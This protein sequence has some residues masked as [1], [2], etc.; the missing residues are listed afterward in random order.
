MSFQSLA[1]CVFLAAA[2]AVCLTLGRRSARLGTQLLAA[3]SLVFYL[4][5]PGGWRTALGGLSVLLLGIAV[6][7]RAI[8]RMAHDVTQMPSS[9]QASPPSTTAC[10]PGPRR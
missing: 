2:L 8:R 4:L 1:F 9:R 5:G 3:A 10:P 7:A 6:T